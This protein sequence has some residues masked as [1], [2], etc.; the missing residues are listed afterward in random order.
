MNR[1]DRKVFHF[2]FLEGRKK[3]TSDYYCTMLPSNSYVKTLS[4]SVTIF[5][6]GDGVYKKV[7]KIKLGHKGRSLIRPLSL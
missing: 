2:S 3:N 5:G 1:K 7:I 4:C 6:D